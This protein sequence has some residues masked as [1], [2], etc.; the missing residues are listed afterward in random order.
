MKNDDF[1]FP[2]FVAAG[3]EEKGFRV[4]SV[5]C[6]FFITLQVILRVCLLFLK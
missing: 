1:F 6:H 2:V 3:I 4:K 5:P